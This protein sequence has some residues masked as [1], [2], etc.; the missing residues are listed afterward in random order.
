MNAG[1]YGSYTADVFVSARAVTR[2]GETVTLGAGG[3]GFGYRSTAA[4]R[5]H[6][7]SSR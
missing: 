6:G 2:A 3:M 4:A 7:R 5:G 1:C